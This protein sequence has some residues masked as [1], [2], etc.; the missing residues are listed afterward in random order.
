MASQIIATICGA[1]H[2][3]CGMDVTVSEGRI[4]RI[5]G[6]RHHPANRGALCVKG[7]AYPEILS[8][9]RRLT[10]PLMK[11]G[12]RQVSVSWDKA[13]A[14][15]AERLQDIC[16]KW[17]PQ[18]VI[19]MRGAPLTEEVREGFLRLACAIGTPNLSGISHLCSVPRQIGLRS[20]I[21]M[22]PEPDYE[23]TRCMV[24]WG[25]NPSNSMR[26]AQTTAAGGFEGILYKKQKE[27]A[28]L[29][30]IDP[31]RTTAAAKADLWL[32]PAHGT[33]MALALAM[34]Q[35]IIAE[36]LYDEA[37]VSRWTLGFEGLKTHVASR[38]PEWAEK[39]TGVPAQDIR[40]AARQ[41]AS[42]RPAVI[43]E[44][45]GLDMHSNV[46]QTVRAIFML[47]AI[48]G[49][50]DVPGGDVDFP[51]PPTAPLPKPSTKIPPMHRATYPLFPSVPLPMVVDALLTGKP[52]PPKAAL[53]YHSN[54][55][56]TIADEEKTRRAFKNLDLLVVSDIAETATT[57]LADFV[58]PDLSSLERLGYNPYTHPDGGF[59]SLR[60]PVVAPVGES[61]SIFDV[62]YE[63]AQR[64]GMAEHYPWKD[65]ESWVNYKIAP[66]KITVSDLREEPTK[67][68]TGPV[69]YRKYETKGF[70][71]PSG[72]VE[73]FSERLQA[74]GQPPYP[75]H[76]ERRAAQDT[77]ESGA[78]P[79]LA[80]SRK[81]MEYVHTK[82][83]D[84]PT[85]K[86]LYPEPLVAINPQDAASRGIQ[87]G[88]IVS[89]A[90]PRG[91][92]TFKAQVNSDVPAGVVQIDFGWGN[93][94]D[95]GCNINV[96]VMDEPHD[97]LTG[98]TSNR[99]FPCQVSK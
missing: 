96:L 84:L 7:A 6:T 36:T 58:L 44:G 43:R 63:L 91:R 1:C 48:T 32:R 8:S 33:D 17:G 37:F 30:V 28:Y 26:V 14:A 78:F 66:S 67:V 31:V 11:Q 92:A 74:I 34:L 22:R 83:R 79:L 93:P 95:G 69:A 90:S 60:Q 61:R 2:L 71:T 76:E 50:L 45:N 42:M 40:K 70:A 89:V 46:A 64:M 3:N 82:Y 99:L 85:L 23:R 87:E 47:S 97:P 98:A 56:L 68:V 10:R 20:L 81:P 62:E 15:I 41:Y 39:I 12:D 72:K 86:K 13:L 59:I 77:A 38:T 9:S 25:G 52:Y 35:T 53:I 51:N 75:V 21:G 55:V 73:F 27:G 65:C 18:S 49:N 19:H 24:L 80:T 5:R 4:S 57:R 88:D 16:A 54:P 29:I 94:G